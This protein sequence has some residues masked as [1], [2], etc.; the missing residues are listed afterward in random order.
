MSGLN[1]SERI[2]EQDRI[3]VS[4]DLCGANNP[5]PLFMKNTFRHVR[6]RRCNMVYVTPRPRDTIRQQENYY[7]H[8]GSL[9]GGCQEMANKD[10]RGSR[11]KKLIA[12]A[13]TYRSYY[14]TGYILDIGCGFGGFLRAASGKGWSHPLGIEIAPQAAV[15][16]QRFFPVKTAELEEDTYEK[17]L[18]DVVRLHN[19]IEH[20]PSPRKLVEV[21]YHILRPGGLFVISTVNFDSFSVTV[22]GS[23]WHYFGGDCHINLFT[24]ETLKFLL[25]GSGFRIIR[26]ET[27]GIHL[28]PKNHGHR[29]STTI[30]RMSARGIKIAEGALG[31][32]I[33]YTSR[34]HHLISWAEKI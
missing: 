5:E 27:K 3:D 8:V 16:A 14:K 9:S 24:P 11:K 23:S 26:L 18:F 15:Y 2:S 33:R 30:E 28:T 29:L 13:G 25:R 34:G 7:E 4:C 12:E 10:Y 22:C 31:I 21:V 32:F 20:L 1:D 6:C 19:V 17:N